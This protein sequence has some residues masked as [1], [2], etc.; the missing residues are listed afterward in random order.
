MSQTN[1]IRYRL[2]GDRVGQAG[3]L[4]IRLIKLNP[5]LFSVLSTIPS[6]ECYFTRPS[7][8]ISVASSGPPVHSLLLHQALLYTLCCFTRPSCT[9]SV[10]SPHPPV[11]SL[12]L[13]QTLFHS[14][15]SFNSL[16]LS[17]TLLN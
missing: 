8:T 9:F 3:V 7:C 13:H 10:A 4:H 6:V 11:H 5:S 2:L 1:A 16:C 17:L 14:L 15:C 12:S